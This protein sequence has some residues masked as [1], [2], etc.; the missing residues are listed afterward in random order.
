M[1]GR[2]APP[3]SLW[4]VATSSTGTRAV[5]SASLKTLTMRERIASA[6]SSRRKWWSVPATSFRKSGASTMRKS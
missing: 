5:A 4:R 1:R 3:S 2:R 6:N